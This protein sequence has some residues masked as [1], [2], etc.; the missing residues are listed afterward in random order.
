[1]AI[2]TALA[3]VALAGLGAASEPAAPSARVSQSCG[4][5]LMVYENTFKRL[6]ARNAYVWV[7]D[8]PSDGRRGY[9]QFQIIVVVGTAY[10]PFRADEGRLDR[11]GF[12]DLMK[13]AYGVLQSRGN[14]SDADMRRGIRIRFTSS[15]QNY[16]LRVSG[17]SL[18]RSDAV[19]V[20][21]C[22]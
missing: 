13:N 12:T 7:D 19:R 3:V 6:E 2:K 5:P 14:V 4:S 22:R 15:R 21:L 10:P 16:E 17:I 20:Q 8:I 9:S 11:R 18:G 1:M